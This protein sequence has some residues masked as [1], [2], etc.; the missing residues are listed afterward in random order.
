MH[1][2]KYPRTFHLPFSEC[3][4]SDDKAL[5]EEQYR[6]LLKKQLVYSE[7]LDGEN[8][9]MSKNW[10]HARSLDS[11]HHP[12]RDFLKGIWSSVRYAIPEDV[13]L[14][15][16]YVYAKHSIEYDLLPGYF[17]LFGASTCEGLFLSVEEVIALA[18]TLALPH[19]EFKRFTGENVWPLRS[20]YNISGECEGYVV[21]NYNSF[22]VESFQENVAKFVR[23][24]HVQTDVHWMHSNIKKNG[25]A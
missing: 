11:V 2:L 13:R 7:K 12:S 18:R 5:S 8:T 17:I 25:L 19:V 9:T 10:V 3:L 22:L 21:R 14:H 4:H 24:D 6:E 23:A 20:A 16:E 15:G 1:K